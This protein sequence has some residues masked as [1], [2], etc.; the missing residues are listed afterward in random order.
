MNA[1][2]LVKSCCVSMVGVVCFYIK[3]TES[4]IKVSFPHIELPSARV[5]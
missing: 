2:T 5:G 4:G 3:L 1:L